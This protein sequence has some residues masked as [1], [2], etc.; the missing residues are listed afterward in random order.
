MN[1]LDIYRLMNDL[2]S[3]YSCCCLSANLY[4]LV[5]Q[6]TLADELVFCHKLL[7]SLL[8]H[9]L[10]RLAVGSGSAWTRMRSAPRTPG[11]ETPSLPHRSATTSFQRQSCLGNTALSDVL[12]CVHGGRGC[13]TNHLEIVIIPVV[14]GR[15]YKLSVDLLSER[16]LSQILQVS[17]TIQWCFNNTL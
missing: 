11:S 9:W 1:L 17:M 4:A 15:F 12:H 10:S 16:L 8:A 14:A 6:G 3:Y 13:T 5:V 7:L 2:K